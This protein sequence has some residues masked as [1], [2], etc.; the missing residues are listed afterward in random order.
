MYDWLIKW[1][2]K[3]N[4]AENLSRFIP[5]IAEWLSRT[6]CINEA[7]VKPEVYNLFQEHG[8]HL[9]RNHYYGVLPETSK[10]KSEWWES[11]P[12]LAPYNSIRKADIES[13]FSSILK[14][15]DDLKPLPREHMDGFYWDND[16]F[17]PLDVIVFYAM[18]REYKPKRLIEIGSGFSTEI[19][20]MASEYTG[21]EIQSIEPYPSERLLSLEPKLK[22][23]T[24]LPVQQ[25]P[26]KE[27]QNLMP[28][29]FLFI[30]TTHTVKLGSDVNYLIFNVLP[31]IQPGVFIHIHDIFLPYEY[32]RRWYDEISIFWNEQYLLMAYLLENPSIEIFLP[33]YYMTIIKEQYLH[34]RFKEFDIWGLENNLGGASGASMWLRKV[35]R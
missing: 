24:L 20:I 30:D 18:L 13:I 11:I 10:L 3:S 12:Y 15:A 14:W 32:P 16:M 4:D 28:G 9:V 22:K 2:L 8:F 29:D 19:A 26:L 27:F 17:P 34:E 7:W 31:I 35:S 33:N 5:P 25:V 21:T 1:L 6:G 23:L